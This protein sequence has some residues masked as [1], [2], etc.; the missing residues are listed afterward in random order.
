MSI[1][2]RV[3]HRVT[4]SIQE[5][6][7][8]LSLRVVYKKVVLYSVGVLYRLGMSYRGRML[9]LVR[10]FYIKRLVSYRQKWFHLWKEGLAY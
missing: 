1:G 6:H 10:V 9:F 4:N 8:M 2:W 3:S 5:V 7:I